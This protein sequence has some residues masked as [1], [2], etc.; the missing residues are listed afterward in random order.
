MRRPPKLLH[1]SGILGNWKLVTSGGDTGHWLGAEPGARSQWSDQLRLVLPKIYVVTQ[2]QAAG[3]TL[4]PLGSNIFGWSDESCPAVPLDGRCYA[5]D[6]M[7]EISCQQ[8]RFCNVISINP[9]HNHFRSIK[10]QSI[11]NCFGYPNIG[12]D[13]D[14]V[15]SRQHRCNY[16]V[17]HQNVSLPNVWDCHR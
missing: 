9:P 14:F 11:G 8:T 16:C 1:I 3:S 15:C 13:G 12:Y 7:M 10:Q 4:G 17:I 5:G 6:Q 2:A